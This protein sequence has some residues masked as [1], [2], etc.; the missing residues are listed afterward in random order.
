M[1]GRFRFGLLYTGAT[2][3]EW[4]ETARRAEDLGFSTLVAQDHSG[5]Q[6]SPLH[7]LVAAEAVTTRLRFGT[8]VGPLTWAR[9]HAGA[10]AAAPTR[11]LPASSAG[12]CGRQPR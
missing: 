11:G 2:L 3:E 4:S 8:T 10:S 1:P 5:A 6:L 7:G 9:A 12:L